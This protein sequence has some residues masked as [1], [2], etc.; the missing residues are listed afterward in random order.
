MMPS[1]LVE[2]Y[3]TNKLPSLKKHLAEWLEVLRLYHTRVEPPWNFRER[4]QVGFFAAASWR[5]QI[6]AIEEWSLVKGPEDKQIKGRCDL[7]I[8]T[9]NFHIEAKHMW[10]RA[11]G[12]ITKEMR[13]IA[14]TQQR[15]IESVSLVNAD[16]RLAFSFLTPFIQKRKQDNLDHRVSFWLDNLLQLKHDAIAWYLPART[17]KEEFTDENLS[18]GCVL[19][20]NK[21]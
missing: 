15:A 2:Y 19:L 11:T 21:I 6:P 7:W 12:N 3:H 8:E 18:I 4:A 16:R 14:N 10:C 5:L 17:R 9:G 1:S 13:Y 20:I